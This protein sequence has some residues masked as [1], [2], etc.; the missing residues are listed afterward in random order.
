VFDPAR[1]NPDAVAAENRRVLDALEA[2][3]LAEVEAAAEEALRSRSS[4]QPPPASAIE[5]VY[6]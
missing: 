3:I 2:A 5:G 6:R 1:R 4:A